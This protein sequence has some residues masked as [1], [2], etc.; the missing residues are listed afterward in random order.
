MSEQQRVALIAGATGLVGG[1]LVRKL[2]VSPLYS[3]VISVTRRKINGP[4]AMISSHRK[5]RQII[6]PL[7]DMET[8]LADQK[9]A[10]DDAY[11]ALGTTIKRAGSQ[12]AFRHVDFDYVVN[13]ARAAKIAGARRFS[14]VSAVGASAKSSIFYSRVK[15]ETED[16]VS[17]MGFDATQ[18]FRPSMLLG[19]RTESRPA[20]TVARVLMPLINPFLMGGASIYRG[21]DPERVAMAMVAAASEE[22]Q[23]RKVY[24]YNEMMERAQ[25]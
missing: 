4:N 17:A 8:C 21:I 6:I 3:Q 25:I 2:L 19:E 10:A 20:E 13:F 1:Y 14:L 24:H 16:A 7:D 5:L 23:G 15:G 18:I 9:I 12:N 11:C 22:A